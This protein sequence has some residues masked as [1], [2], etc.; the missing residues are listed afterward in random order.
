MS[1][2]RQS[3]PRAGPRT[4]DIDVTSAEYGSDRLRAPG[5]SRR[6]RTGRDAENPSCCGLSVRKLRT[7]RL[8]PQTETLRLALGCVPASS[9]S[10]L[11]GGVECSRTSTPPLVHGGPDDRT[12]PRTAECPVTRALFCHNRAVPGRGCPLCR[13]IPEFD[14][15]PD[16]RSSLLGQ[17]SFLILEQSH[18]HLQFTLEFKEGGLLLG[19]GGECRHTTPKRRP[20]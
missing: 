6:S 18:Q 19:V 17:L 4:W 10:A 16:S 8:R 3:R 12:G 14:L 1:G 2:I 9:R 11:A 20:S 15:E 5:S 7:A 13:A